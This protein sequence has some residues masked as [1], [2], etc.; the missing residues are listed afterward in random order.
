MSNH[1]E[2]V[3]A[4]PPPD[5]GRAYAA[6]SAR[7]GRFVRDMFNNTA[8]HYDL[9][10]RI[11][12]MGSGGWYRRACLHWGGLRP[13]MQAVDVAVGTG[14]LAQEMIAL[15]GGQCAVIGLDVS[16]SM[17]AIAKAKLE[18]PLVQAA[19]EAL[20][21]ASA[22]ADF[23]A[24]GYALRHIADIPAALREA[25]RILR[26]GGTVL[27]L[28]IS[29]PRHR[30]ARALAAAYIGGLVPLMSLVTT[31][32]QGARTLMRYH[33]DTI[34]NHMRPEAVQGALAASGFKNVDCW[35]ELDLFHCYAGT[36]DMENA[37]LPPV[38]RSKSARENFFF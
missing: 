17:L 10:N 7:G 38:F 14:L 21:L 2:P 4:A 28:E 29:A 26:P 35:S 37:T 16:E 3:L 20:P 31:R 11:F 18:I 19:A 24:M 36:K 6:N 34:L 15:T 22:S 8:R 9:A 25:L 5:L 13:G 33:W 23:V 30:L 12:S 27:L 32:D 1:Q